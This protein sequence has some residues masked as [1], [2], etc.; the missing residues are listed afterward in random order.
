VPGVRFQV[1]AFCFLRSADC[2]GRW[3]RAPGIAPIS[4]NLIVRPAPKPAWA[5]VIIL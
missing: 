3:G 4:A 2:L 1:S 5:G